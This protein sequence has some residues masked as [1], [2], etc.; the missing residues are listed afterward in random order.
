MPIHFC[1][2]CGCSHASRAEFSSCN[3]D[4]MAHKIENVDSLALFQK[5]FARPCINHYEKD[6]A[7][8]EWSRDCHFISGRCQM[9]VNMKRWSSSLL[10]REIQMKRLLGT[11]L[12][13]TRMTKMETFKTIWGGCGATGMFLSCWGWE[14]DAARRYILKPIMCIPYNGAV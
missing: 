11:L 12:C 1:V 10:L 6:N 2:V 3:R 14:I 8:A 5:K 9:A 7:T 13:A 4:H